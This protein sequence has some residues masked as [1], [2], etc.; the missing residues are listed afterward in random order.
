MIVAW[1]EVPGIASPKNSR[2]V[3]TYDSAGVRTEDWRE[4]N[5]NAVGPQNALW[6]QPR[7]IIPYPTGRFF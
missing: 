5:S 7:P 2:P 4:K 1:H 6:D 3:G